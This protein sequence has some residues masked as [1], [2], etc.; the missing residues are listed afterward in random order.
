[1]ISKT[2]VKTTVGPLLDD[3]DVLVCDDN[4]MG[5]MLNTF[6]LLFLPRNAKIIFHQLRK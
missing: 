6:L 1:M 4:E 3:N 2:T 5:E